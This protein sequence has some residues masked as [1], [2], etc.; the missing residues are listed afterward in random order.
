MKHLLFVVL[1]AVSSLALGNASVV[2]PAECAAGSIPV[3][4]PAGPSVDGPVCLG[5]SVRD[6]AGKIWT[7]TRVGTSTGTVTGGAYAFNAASMRMAGG[8][9]EFWFPYNPSWLYWDSADGGFHPVGY[10]KPPPVTPGPPLP[11]GTR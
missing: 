3:L 5:Q 9:A 10:V 4:V 6:S 2:V 8:R 1:F 11:P 7:Y